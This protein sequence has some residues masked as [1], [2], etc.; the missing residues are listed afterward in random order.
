MPQTTEA[1]KPGHLHVTTIVHPTDFSAAGTRACDY[2]AML[3]RLTGAE[4]HLV[5][6]VVFP[7]VLA[8][9]EAA[10]K[11]ACV[12][13]EKRLQEIGGKIEGVTSLKTTVR[14]G[15]PHIEV[16]DYAHK[17]KADLVVMGTVGL[18]HDAGNPVGSTAEKV[19]R[20]LDIPVLTVKSP[21]A[22]KTARRTCVLCAQHSIDVLCDACKERIRGE[23]AARV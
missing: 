12:A 21:P 13:A 23:A 20:A 19:L 2:A 17:V 22:P 15:S 3:C 11:K 9:S 16:I 14:I 7:E 10:V 18:T 1:R 5:H 4:L 8:P 6:V